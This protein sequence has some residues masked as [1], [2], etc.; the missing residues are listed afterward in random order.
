MRFPDFPRRLSYPGY[1]AL[2]LNSATFLTF[3]ARLGCRRACFAYVNQLYTNFVLPKARTAAAKPSG[4]TFH[5]EG[6]LH[7]ALYQG[8]P[9][10]R[11]KS[12]SR[13]PLTSVST[14]P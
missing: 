11:G 12:G 10:R 9:L 1:R 3:S 13:R 5:V 4:Q 14:L 6:N 8:Y 2:L 7:F